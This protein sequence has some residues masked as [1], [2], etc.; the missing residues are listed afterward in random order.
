[1]GQ[2]MKCFDLAI[3][4]QV[5]KR[6][7]EQLWYLGDPCYVVDDEDW[8]V[9]VEKVYD[10]VAQ[11]NGAEY[12]MDSIMY[13]KD[14]RLEIWSNG[15][16]GTWKF[17]FTGMKEEKKP[18]NGNKAKFPVDSG[19]FCII[20]AIICDVY[21]IDELKRL[22]MVFRHKP[23]LRVEDGVVYV[24]DVH[25]DSVKECYNCDKI[26]GHQDEDWCENGNCVGC[27]ECFECECEEE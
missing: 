4:N 21:D 27:W 6:S 18:L 17:D 5:A 22:G 15:G 23:E 20:P 11:K 9:F 2:V 16:D 3:D 24:N 13:W 7:V 14:E 8:H 10:D 12:G 25:D 1:M 26:I 19:H